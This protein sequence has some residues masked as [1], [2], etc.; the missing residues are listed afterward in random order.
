MVPQEEATLMTD[1]CSA[2]GAD[3]LEDAEKLLWDGG[4]SAKAMLG[5]WL[6]AALVTVITIVVAIPV[7]GLDR[8]LFL[9]LLCGALCF[10]GIGLYVMYLKLSVRYT[11][12]SQRFVRQVGLLGCV[13]DRMEMIDADDVAFS[14][15]PLQRMA[16]V[17]TIKIMSG[18]RSHPE[19]FLHGIDRVAHVA[20]LIDDA[21]RVE[22]RRR[23]LF[24]EI[25]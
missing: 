15:R 3:V 8:G 5:G 4:Y 13:T 20:R 24:I 6:L 7:L 17:G 25:T 9:G 1:R 14:Q 22:R 11:L 21:R 10:G 23:G 16:G 18:G 19:L 2:C 12:T